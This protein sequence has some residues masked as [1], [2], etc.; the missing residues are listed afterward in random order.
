MPDILNL[1][2]LASSPVKDII[3]ESSTN[4]SAHQDSTSDTLDPSKSKYIEIYEQDE[5]HLDLQ[6]NDADNPKLSDAVDDVQHEGDMLPSAGYNNTLLE[7]RPDALLNRC[8][9]SNGVGLDLSTGP[10]RESHF[11]PTPSSVAFI[12]KHESPSEPSTGPA[13]IPISSPI[14][15]ILVTQESEHTPSP[16][17]ATRLSITVPSPI[18]ILLDIS[19]PTPHPLLAELAKTEHR[20]DTLQR[21]LRDCHLALEALTVSL[22][23]KS[24]MTG[25]VLRG[26]AD[27]S[28]AAE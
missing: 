25:C 17:P 22:A 4:G 5:S 20:C 10:D 6:L 8:F 27:G 13:S 18:V 19:K 23:P 24:T 7:E 14:P 11:P 12:T 21:S 3:S 26:V 16:V 9:F 28:A 15:T 1:E 2:F